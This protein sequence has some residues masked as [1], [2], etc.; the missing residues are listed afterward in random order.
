LATVPDP[1]PPTAERRRW[2]QRLAAHL[3]ARDP[4]LRAT[5]RSVRAAVVVPAAFAIARAVS[6]DANV[7]LF[8]AF[9]AVALLLF[10]DFPGRRGTQLRHLGAL[11]VV[12]AVFIVVG[13]VSSADPVVA[14]VVTAVV[15][16]AVLFGGILSPPVTTATMAALLAFVLSV[17]VS[18]P[19][20]AIPG[21]LAGWALAAV[22]SVP[23]VLLVW[24]RPFHDELR[25][26]LSD[27]ARSLAGLVG[28]HAEGR[29]DPDGVRVA[30]TELAELR[31]QFESTTAPPTGASP[32]DSALAKLVCRMEWVG[33]NAVLGHQQALALDLPDVR[34]VN[35]AAAEVLT[36][37]ADLLCDRRGCTVDDPAVAGR[38]EAAVG[39]LEAQR[40]RSQQASMERVLDGTAAR[41]ATE[42]LALD[43][44][45]PAARLAG[46]RSS[47]QDRILGAL[48]PTFRTRALSYAA[49]MVAEAAVEASGLDRPSGTDARRRERAIWGSAAQKAAAHADLRSVWFRNSL[50]GA[51]GLALAVAVAEATGV[52]HGFWVVLGT[53]SVLRSNAT[54]TGATAL[55]ALVGTVVGFVVGSLVMVGVGDHFGVLWALLPLAVLLSGF[56]PAAVS[57]PAGQAAFTVLVV[58]LFNIIDPTGWKVGLTRVEDV[59]IGCGVSVVVGFLFWPRGAAAALGRA[60]GE[61]YAA[62]SAYLLRAVERATSPADDLETDVARRAT[63]GAF[64]RMEDAYREYVSERGAKPIAL[65]TATTLAV[66]A[67]RTRTA[68]Y[69]LATLPRRRIDPDEGEL[70]S[71]SAAGDSLWRSCSDAHHWYLSVGDVL[72]GRATTVPPLRHHEGDLHQLLVRAFL[73][74]TTRRRTGDV[75]AV[76]RML[77]ADESL[78]DEL[79]LQRELAGTVAQFAQQRHGQLE[80]VPAP[81]PAT[82]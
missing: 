58:I 39:D 77:W 10:V 29:R 75:R 30:E 68:A 27:T 46:T 2:G 61:A 59:A 20:S 60:L 79:A 7:Q 72:A 8:A 66:G 50:R 18:A 44:G 17:S 69:S 76:L 28:A 65:A 37:A 35:R 56:A 53:L 57:F 33:T 40:D 36:A 47:Q 16:F 82:S 5:K 1:D 74:S 41:R 11:V 49:E 71:V 31:A 43:G 34:Q 9:G 12:G 14:V 80:P 26:K 63:M 48:D 67:V 55:R 32:G 25:H 54:G 3:T 6:A 62:G 70:E 38:V 42:A 78:E 45:E 4:S 23:A 51:V 81:V 24:P 64:A 21:R 73:D 19:A 13:T 22:L 52:A 15:A